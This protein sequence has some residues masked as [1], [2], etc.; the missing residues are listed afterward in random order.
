MRLIIFGMLIGLVCGPGH[1][2]AAPQP[3]PGAATA[4][5]PLPRERPLEA[6][7]RAPEEPPEPTLPSTCFIALT[8]GVAVAEALP[9]IAGANGCGAQDVVRLDAVLLKDQR[10]V[11]FKPAPVLRCGMATALA[12][13]LRED[14]DA[15]VAPLGAQ[16]AGVDNYNSYECRPRN[17]IPGAET[18]EHGR[19]N[20][21]DVRGFALSNGQRFSL[22]DPEVKKSVRDNLKASACARFMTVLGPGSDGYHEEHIHLD[23]AERRNNFRL[24]QW[25]VNVPVPLPRPRP[26]EAPAR[27][28]E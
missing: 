14:V 6:G 17:N 21:I 25:D 3:Q 7:P 8:S 15:Q 12:N 18:S 20:A 28:A 19:A 22:T 5:V 1:V 13:W 26:A 24:C 2:Q 10:R 9:P 4:A 27:A 16:L 11:A 23:L